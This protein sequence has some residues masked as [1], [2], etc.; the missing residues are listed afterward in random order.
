MNLKKIFKEWEK[1]R[2]IRI[3]SHIENS[4]DRA[5]NNPGN[6]RNHLE[7][8]GILPT[9]YHWVKCCAA[10]RCGRM[11]LL[12]FVY[13]NFVSCNKIFQ[14]Y[15]I[16]CATI[17][18]LIKKSNYQILKADCSKM[19]TSTVINVQRMN[20]AEK[21]YWRQYLGVNYAYPNLKVVRTKVY[22][23]P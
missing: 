11:D 23:Q 21:A 13:Q 20:L 10:L 16:S 3:R 9:I 19:G 6:L 7:A 8:K 17:Q 2:G 4:P 22:F 12:Y 14:H 18:R 15:P 5:E 1:R